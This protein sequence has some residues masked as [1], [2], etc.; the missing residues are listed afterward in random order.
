MLQHNFDKYKKYKHIAL[1]QYNVVK[2]YFSFLTIGEFKMK[3]SI[4][5][6]VLFFGNSSW[7]CPEIRESRTYGKCDVEFTG[8]YN[9]D[10]EVA[11]VPLE[12]KIAS[13]KS[14]SG[15]NVYNTEASF[16]GNRKEKTVYSMAVIN[17]TTSEGTTTNSCI[18]NQSFENLRIIYFVN[19]VNEKE[20]LGR[21]T[22]T[23]TVTDKNL[24]ISVRSET[25]AYGDGNF[26]QT[27]TCTRK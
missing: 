10:P 20:E 13:I 9:V 16:P 1:T 2:H 27:T 12:I 21:F 5:F 8:D 6:L 14:F 26:T 17:E 25:N 22:T 24:V 23:Y 18:D 4:F 15:V 11:E 7:S 19:E 3:I